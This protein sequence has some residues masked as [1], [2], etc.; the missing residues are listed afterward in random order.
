ML[1]RTDHRANQVVMLLR[2]A[3]AV[4]ELDALSERPILTPRQQQR[5]RTLSK[6]R[7]RLSARLRGAESGPSHPTAPTPPADRAT[8]ENEN[9]PVRDHR[10][11]EF[12]SPRR[13]EC[14]PSREPRQGRP[15]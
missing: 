10:G 8:A 6:L 1:K 7:H 2:L 9:A 14:E 5:F 15:A 3:K 4:L 11:V 13:V 12:A